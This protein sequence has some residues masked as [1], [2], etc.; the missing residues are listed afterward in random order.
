MLKERPFTFPLDKQLRVICDTDAYNEA[1]DQYCIAHMLMTPRFDVKALIAAQFGTE[2]YPD[3]ELESYKEI[4]HIV[5]LMNL[6]GEVNILHG[7]PTC[8]ADEKT[9]IESEG[10]RFIV[11]EAMKDDPR[12]LFVCCTAAS[13][14]VACAYLMEPEIAKKITVIWIGGDSYPKGGF[15]YNLHNDK[16]AASVLLGSDIEL[17]QVPK[18][19][20]ITMKVSFFE[21]MNQVYPCGELGKYLVEN[22][23]RV[24]EWEARMMENPST[25]LGSRYLTMSRA[26]AAT[27]FAGELW[28]LGDSPV[29]GLMLNHTLGHFHMEDAPCGVNEDYTYDYSRPGKRQIRVYDDIDGRFIVNDFFEKIKYYFR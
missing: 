6:D 3:T 2:K 5:H 7:A 26:A 25:P 27:S 22:T 29:V 13:T 1:D 14:N 16:K 12:P 4:Q 11:E 17:W 19:V 24:A 20:Y 28:C 18:S 8:L 21:L 10:A 15:E 9:P 23:M